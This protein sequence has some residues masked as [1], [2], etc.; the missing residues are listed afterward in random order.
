MRVEAYIDTNNHALNNALFDE[1]AANA[2]AWHDQ[3]GFELSWERLDRAS[4]I[5][6]Y[7]PVDL[8]DPAD[9]EATRQWGVDTLVAMYNTLN[10][11][12]R[13]TAK[14]RR[15]EFA[16]PELPPESQS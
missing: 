3:C 12:L 16:G 10:T 14:A 2:T 4:R 8:D 6:A 13:A 7:K 5:A 15:A 11:P 1:F 9:R